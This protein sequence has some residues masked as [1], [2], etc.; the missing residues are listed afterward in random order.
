MA[1]PFWLRKW[2]VRTGLARWSPW[3]RR[4]GD[5]VGPF[6]HHYG[7]RTLAAPLDELASMS[8]WFGP[9]RPEVIDLTQSSPRFDLAPS[10]LTRLPAERRGYPPPWGLPELRQALIDQK[11][12]RASDE[13]LI[14]HGAAGAL[15]TAF[16]AFLKTLKK[17]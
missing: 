13:A 6:L 14:T 5:G 15:G 16:D 8:D 2:C 1:I 9:R 4:H 11:F 12:V 7:D 10:G 3:V 17:G